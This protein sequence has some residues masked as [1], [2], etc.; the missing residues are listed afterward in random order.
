MRK[1]FLLAWA[2]FPVITLAQNDNENSYVNAQNEIKVN[3]LY[4]VAGAVEI[5]YE[6]Y[7]NDES[8][9]GIS[10]MV[11]Y[12]DDSDVNY[13]I[14]P[15]YRIYFG[16]NPVSGFYL[17]GFGMLNSVK[18]DFYIISGF[19]PMNDNKNV[20]DFALGI[21]LGGK[22]VTKGNFIGEIGVGFGRNLFENNRDYEFVGKIGITVGYRF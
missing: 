20:T 22:W 1:L 5:T 15:Y 3:A 6:R 12:I 21:G 17:E 4:L 14:S 2:I 18:E 19:D 10:A 16:K 7:L 13:Y 8:S 9:F 11:P